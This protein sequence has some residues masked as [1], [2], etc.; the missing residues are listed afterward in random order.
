[1][2]QT[3]RDGTLGSSVN[4]D[5]KRTEAWFPPFRKWESD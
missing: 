1:M 3:F 5:E 2:I 4:N